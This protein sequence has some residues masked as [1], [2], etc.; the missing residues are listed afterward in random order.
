VTPSPLTT[1]LDRR[2][3]IAQRGSTIQREILAGLTTF[4]AMAY[5]MAVNPAI[6][7][8]AGLLPHDMI[9]T[10]IAAAICGTLLMA[11]FANMPIALA[12]A[13]SSNA[14]FAQIVV[15][16]MHVDVR[17]A[18]TIVLFGGIAFTALSVTRLRHRIIQAFP[19][20][21][22][23]GI[24]VAIGIFIARL[25]MVTGGLAIGAPDGFHFGALTD[26]SVLLT[27]FGLFLA[28]V[29]LVL[30]VPAG[31]LIAILAVTL[32]SLFVHKNGHTVASLPE[33]FMDWPHYPTHLLFPFNFGDFFSHLDLLLPITLYFLISDF[34]DATGT[35]Y[36]V[37]NRARLTKPDGTTLLG[38]A[39]FAADGSASIIGSA[40]GTST[41]SAYVESLVGVEAG[42][43]TGLTALT[44]AL[45]FAAS[46]VLWPLIVMIPAE[47]TAPVLI[48][49]GLSMLSALGQAANSSQEALLTPAFMLLIAVL[50]GNFMI[51]L[52]L[53]LLFYSL[54]LLVTRQF[55]RL[56][57]MVLGLDAVF[58]FYL[59]LTSHT[60]IGQGG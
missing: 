53:G 2:F 24:Q 52:A 10:T 6:M 35:M 60:G 29:L 57:P 15:H 48:L 1:W 45:L 55:V 26:P 49:V 59:V 4:G 27:L 46:S 21:I 19:E 17:T 34:F 22:V 42:G 18:F 38:R 28:S 47:A 9:M 32:A 25:G 41:V 54:L 58:I 51:S 50:T 33:H 23:L 3:R 37:A 36:S 14:I 31:M 7:A 11:L 39:A 13:M 16:Q 44:V 5:I 56:T 8:K 30:R 43:R 12:P 20:P 40:L